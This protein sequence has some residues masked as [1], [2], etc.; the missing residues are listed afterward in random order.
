MPMEVSRNA[1]S[2]KWSISALRGSQRAAFFFGGGGGRE[3]GGLERWERNQCS[4][5][6]VHA[7]AG[8]FCFIF[9]IADGPQHLMTILPV[10][11]EGLPISSGFT[12]FYRDASSTLSQLV[13]QWLFF[14]N[15]L[16]FSRFPLREKEKKNPA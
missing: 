2:C 4:C 1:A 11:T 6:V 3:R 16:T 5:I 7:L 10:V 12:K 14:F 8:I 9:L 13:F 15:L